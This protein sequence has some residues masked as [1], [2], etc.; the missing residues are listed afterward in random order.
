MW[1]CVILAYYYSA[2]I[3]HKWRLHWYQ[4]KRRT[5]VVT[6]AFVWSH[7]VTI[8]F[9]GCDDAQSQAHFIQRFI[10][11][12]YDIQPLSPQYCLLVDRSPP[13]PPLIF[14]S[15]VIFKSFKVIFKSQVI[16]NFYECEKSFT[17]VHTRGAVIQ[18]LYSTWVYPALELGG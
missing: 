6:Y 1:T 14:K 12:F 3:Q 13:I 4:I 11:L 10:I 5:C 8:A 15:Q 7:T 2:S 9:Y 17:F 18:V 16:F